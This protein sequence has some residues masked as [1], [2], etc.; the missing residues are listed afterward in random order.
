MYPGIIIYNTE[1]Y[2]S[3]YYVQKKKSYIIIYMQAFKKIP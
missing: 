1:L 2:I 3:T